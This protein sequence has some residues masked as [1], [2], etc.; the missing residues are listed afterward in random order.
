MRHEERRNFRGRCRRQDRVGPEQP[1]HQ[2]KEIP[3][4][5]FQRAAEDIDGAEQDRTTRGLPWT[6]QGL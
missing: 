4:R 1:R 5:R 3:P 2:V 6:D